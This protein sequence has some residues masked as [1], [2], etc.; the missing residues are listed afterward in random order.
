M[1]RRLTPANAH[2]AAV[3]LK[4]QVEA[5]VYSKGEQARVAVPVVDLCRTPSGPRDR[6]LVLGEAVTVYDRRDG[7]AFVQAAR[8]G[9]VGHLPEIALGPD[10]APTHWIAV[11]ASHAYTAADV[12][13]PEAKALVFG[14]M[15]QCV[16][17]TK[18]FRETGDSLH[19]P[20]PHLWPIGKRYT[21]PVTVAQLHFAAPYLWGGNTIRGI[22]CSGLVQAA[23]LS[24]GIDCPGDSD[25]QQAVGE[26][27]APEAPPERGDLLFWHGHVALCVDSDTLIHANAHHMAVAYEPIGNAI[28][29]IEAQGD[30]TVTSRR[31]LAAGKG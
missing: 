20:K 31:R 5:P 17:E 10:F 15:V 25:L 13:A 16:G 23:L 12:K 11:P 3:Y 24:C 6:Q 7:W 30:G 14:S 2:V 1:D 9:Y 21:D 27:L 22:D 29:R 19:I 18:R 8:D 26:P 28:A 4:G